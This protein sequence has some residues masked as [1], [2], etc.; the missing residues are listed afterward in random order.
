MINKENN[1]KVSELLKQ[2]LSEA[3]IAKRLGLRIKEVIDII[4]RM[5]SK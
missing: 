2:N 5:S 3:E 4:D 1:K